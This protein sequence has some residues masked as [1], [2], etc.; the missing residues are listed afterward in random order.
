MF[1]FFYG[2]NTVKNLVIYKYNYINNIFLSFNKKNIKLIKLK[3]I[4]LKK[5]INLTILNSNVFKKKFSKFN[6]VH[7]GV[8]AIVKKNIFYNN[9]KKIFNLI[10]KKSKLLFLII[11]GIN[12]PYNL[13]SCIR[14]SVAFNV[15]AIIVS[16]Y[17]TV[18]IENNIVHKVSTG[19]IYKVLIIQVSNLYNII[20]ILQKNN[21]YIL[22][23]CLNSNN[24]INN[25]NFFKYNL[26]ALIIGSEN[27][28]IRISIK[29]KCNM[30]FNI[31]M[32]NINSLNVSVSYGIIIYNIFIKKKLK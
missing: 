3:E 5:K 9:K 28:G 24:S 4:I 1:N 8:I 29:K 12:S 13:G 18:D 10:K 32:F 25:I 6:F 27:K 21:F 30:L 2:I 26:C 20:N 7:Q 22:G 15:D 17:N 19:S 14:T 16:K 23:T 31:P 11:D